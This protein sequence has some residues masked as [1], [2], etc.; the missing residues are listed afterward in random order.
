MPNWKKFMSGVLGAS[1]MLE[2]TFQAYRQKVDYQIELHRGGKRIL[3]ATGHIPLGL[4]PLILARS[5]N[6]PNVLNFFLREKPDVLINK[7]PAPI[8][9]SR[10][11]KLGS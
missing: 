2:Q 6:S 11:R 7:R 5:S 3:K 1:L 10:K 9:V 4:W 8:R